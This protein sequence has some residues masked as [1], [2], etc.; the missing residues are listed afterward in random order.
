M[1]GKDKTEKCPACGLM[2]MNKKT[3]R[4][5]FRGCQAVKN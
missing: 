5:S 2:T 3:G 1:F 4:C